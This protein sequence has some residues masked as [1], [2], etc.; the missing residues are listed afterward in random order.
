MNAD[1]TDLKNPA[2]RLLDPCP[3][4][5][6]LQKA[7]KQVSRRNI[8]GGSFFSRDIREI[9][10]QMLMEHTKIIS[11]ILILL[12]S[13][14]LLWGSVVL[15]QEEDDA[16][17][18]LGAQVYVENCAVCHGADG[19]GRVGATLSKDW[20][21]IRPDLVALDTIAKGVEGSPMP[22]WGQEYGGPLSDEEIVAVVFYILSWQ[23]GGAP[24]ITPQYTATAHPEISPVPDVAGDPNQGASLY[25]QN[26]AVC[27]GATGEGRIGVSLAKAWPSFRADLSIKATIERGV[28]NSPM[29]AWSQSNGGPL[30]ESEINDLV[31]FVMSWDT[32]EPQPEPTTEPEAASPFSGLAGV[33]FTAVAFLLLILAF[34]LGQRLSKKQ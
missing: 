14:S 19:E 32:A 34:T 1:F 23:T 20:P 25:D 7:T 3:S 28:E 4:V 16:Q 9:R 12:L 33:A 18:Q 31:A 2:Q 6:L 8:W 21:S 26:C 30:S 27:H 5:T 24:Q 29:P 11:R 17:G 15:A 22:A 10:V 13:V